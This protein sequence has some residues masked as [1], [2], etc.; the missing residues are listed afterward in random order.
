VKA[1]PSGEGTLDNVRKNNFRHNET[2]ACMRISMS[3]PPAFEAPIPAQK[4]ITQRS[5]PPALS[6]D[7]GQEIEEAQS[8]A[9]NRP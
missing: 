8:L 6:H 4:K 9:G 1:D 3:S 2:T 5:R 7:L